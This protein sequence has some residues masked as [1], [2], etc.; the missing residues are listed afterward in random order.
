M[1]NGG[2]RIG[3]ATSATRTAA[4]ALVKERYAGLADAL[5]MIGSLQIQNRAT[6]VGNVCNAS[7]SA[8]A[9]PVLLCLGARL[10]IAGRSG[11]REAEI[12]DIYDVP[13]R[14]RLAPGEWVTAVRL[15]ALVARTATAY[16]RFTPRRELD[17]AVAGAAALVTLDA[18]G[19]F[20]DV[21]IA[22]AS[23]APTPI[24]APTAEARL[25]AARPD[26]KLL[27][28]AGRLAS[29]DCAPISDTRGSAEYRRELVAV[30]TGRALARCC[31]RLGVGVNAP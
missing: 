7:P 3:A 4:S 15:P 25:L 8:D 13:G 28:E 17:I 29:R 2:V 11:L 30:L 12:A 24:R 27:A 22:L 26:T 31:E 23:V 20:T 18:Q 5:G 10:D 21:R 6:L 9:P 19:H 14:T 1:A 16:V